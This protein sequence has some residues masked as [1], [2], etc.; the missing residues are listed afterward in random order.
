MACVSAVWTSI[1]SIRRGAT[2]SDEF[3][4]VDEDKGLATALE[5]PEER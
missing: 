5:K 4:V 1:V 2:S 3:A